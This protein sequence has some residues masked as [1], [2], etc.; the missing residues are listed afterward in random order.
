VVLRLISGLAMVSNRKELY[1]DIKLND[2][3]C[4]LYQTHMATYKRNV[5]KNHEKILTG[6]SDIGMRDMYLLE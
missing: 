1:A 3:L 6:S 5:L 2:T 4:A